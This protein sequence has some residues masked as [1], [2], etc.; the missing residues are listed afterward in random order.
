MHLARERAWTFE[1]RTGHVD[2]GTN[3]FAFFD[4]SLYLQIEI[5]LDTA[6]GADAG[7]AAR[8]IKTRKAE[9]HVVIK[10]RSARVKKMIV[11]TYQTRQR[12]IAGKIQALGSGG[13]QERRPDVRDLVP[14]E[15]D[16]LVSFGCGAGA[17]DHADVL[18]GHKS[19]SR[20]TNEALN[21]I[22]FLGKAE[23]GSKKHAKHDGK[24]A[25]GM[26]SG[27]FMNRRA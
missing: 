20:D 23:C 7:D 8:E 12:R 15:Q 22:L 5:R 4:S 3:E 18:E 2:F 11:H 10:A 27:D 6:R 1:I 14:G 17:I 21:R 25:H 24:T 26:A 13:N 9:G 16:G 19:T